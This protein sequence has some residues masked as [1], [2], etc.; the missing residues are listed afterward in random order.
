LDEPYDKSIAV[1]RLATLH[2]YSDPRFIATLG[3]ML[4]LDGKFT[5]ADEVFAKSL[6]LGLASAELHRIEFKPH[7]PCN[8]AKPMRLKGS[9]AAVKNSYAFIDV[10]GYPRVICP[11]G[12]WFGTPMRQGLGVEFEIVFSPKGALADRPTAL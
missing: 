7:E 5:E 2:G 3:G 12:R 8:P 6:K 11:G 9:V 1:L 4:F 10:P